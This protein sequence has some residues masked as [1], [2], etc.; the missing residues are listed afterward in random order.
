MNVY[1]ID[2]RCAVTACAKY[3]TPFYNLTVDRAVNEELMA[4]GE[5]EVMSMEADEV[6]TVVN[7]FLMSD[8]QT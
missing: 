2:A 4:S 8:H 3:A 1:N 5:F 6:R 7:C